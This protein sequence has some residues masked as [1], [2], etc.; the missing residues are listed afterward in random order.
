MVAKIRSISLPEELDKWLDDT[1]HVN[2]SKIVQV[3]IKEHI[4]L[5]N[6]SATFAEN[7]ALRQRLEGVM[8]NLQ[9]R[10]EFIEKKGLFDEFLKFEQ[11]Q[12]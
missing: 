11:E 4:Q 3:A 8:K 7:Q 10:A 1:P 2:L 9:L 12:E 5:E 6:Q